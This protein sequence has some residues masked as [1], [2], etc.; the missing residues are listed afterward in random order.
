MF[1]S[2]MQEEPDKVSNGWNFS[3]SRQ[4][5]KDTAPNL[6]P[7]LESLSDN[8]STSSFKRTQQITETPLIPDAL[9][10]V[11]TADEGGNIVLSAFGTF[12]IA[13]VDLKAATGTQVQ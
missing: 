2:A 8:A 5:Y 9:H 11:V 1:P 13:E 4:I 10:V 7:P 6:L 3:D 12:R